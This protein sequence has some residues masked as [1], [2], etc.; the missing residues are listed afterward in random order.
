MNGHISLR[1]LAASIFS[2]VTFACGSALAQ[3]PAAPAA[4]DPGGPAIALI[5]TGVDY[6]DPAIASRLARDG[7]GEPIAWDFVD[8]DLKPFAAPSDRT[9]D[10]TRLAKLILATD[11]KARLIVVRVTRNEPDSLAKAVM[12]IARTP[13]TVAVVGTFPQKQDGWDRFG[14]AASAAAKNVLFFVPAGMPDE[15]LGGQA[16]PVG[17]NL[18]NIL[19]VAPLTPSSAENDTAEGAAPADVWVKTRETQVND[20]PVV[21]PS[22]GLQ[23]AALLGGYTTCVLRGREFTQVAAAKAAL[24]EFASSV[25]DNGP[26]NVYDTVCEQNNEPKPSP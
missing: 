17:L 9:D 20:Q 3:N 19:T 15:A 23:A 12:F 6:T 21:V 11:D 16:Y 25:G 5:S 1:S 4:L 24:Q 26:K 2:V 18:E 14:G 22:D 13:A 7:E 10:G 8:N